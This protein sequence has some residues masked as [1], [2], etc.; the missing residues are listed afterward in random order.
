VDVARTF[1]DKTL[2]L[3]CFHDEPLARLP[4]FREVYE[5]T[6][7]ILYHSPEEQ[8]LAES[9][10]GLN[11]PGAVCIG[12]VIDTTTTGNAARGRQLIGAERYVLYCG[13]YIPQKGVDRLC[14]YARRHDAEYPGRFT[15][16]FLG[17]GNL[18]IPREPW[19]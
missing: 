2:L 1:P 4:T 7:G 9:E 13:R 12:T 19:A 15:F 16:V 14:E 3:P 18:S 6:A 5:R 17:Q 11:H 8:H 10:V